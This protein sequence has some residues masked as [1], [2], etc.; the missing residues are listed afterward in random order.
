MALEYCKGIN[1][2]TRQALRFLP[3]TMA[4]VKT[5]AYFNIDSTR[6]KSSLVILDTLVSLHTLETL[7]IWTLWLLWT[8]WTLWNQ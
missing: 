5:L 7:N 2:Q 3:I 6:L 8:L 1:M 4:N